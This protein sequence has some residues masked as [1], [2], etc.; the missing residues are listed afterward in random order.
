MI[1]QNVSEQLCVRTVFCV[2]V[3]NVNQLCLKSVGSHC[4]TIKFMTVVV[5]KVAGG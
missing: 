2:D 1:F 4:I 3:T 5:L